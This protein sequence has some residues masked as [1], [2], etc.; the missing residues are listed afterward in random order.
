MKEVHSRN[1]PTANNKK[2]VNEKT[3][4]P[5]SSGGLQRG[6]EEGSG[7]KQKEQH[8]SEGGAVAK[9]TLRKKIEAIR[10]GHVTGGYCETEALKEAEKELHKVL[11]AE[12]EAEIKT[13]GYSPDPKFKAPSIRAL[14]IELNGMAYKPKLVV[15]H[16]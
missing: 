15:T 13:H 5:A 7:S 6:Q 11:S 8:G 1:Y 16:D 12:L 10:K 3:N 14:E 9:A 2:T 4:A